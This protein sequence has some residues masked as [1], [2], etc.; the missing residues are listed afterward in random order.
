MH[1]HHVAFRTRDLPRL[2]RFYEE[3]LGLRRVR[4]QPGY[5]V[6]LA[7]GDAVLM[8]ERADAG[9]PAPPPG[10]RDLLA[11][12][13]TEAE[14]TAIRARVAVE[15]ETAHTTYFRDPDG[16]RIAVSTHPLER[17]DR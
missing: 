9:E 4:E 5:S 2:A 12:R 7:L 15:G 13:V 3:A 1:V 17:A 11:F 10:G 14:R 6:W 8:L 16:R